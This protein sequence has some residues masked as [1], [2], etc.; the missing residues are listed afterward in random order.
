MKIN[1]I[2]E[3]IHVDS[4]GNFYVEHKNK[5][6]Q[7]NV[8][9]NNEPYFD[10]GDYSI[11]SD[12][13]PSKCDMVITKSDTFVND[14]YF[15]E[16]NGHVYK[17]IEYDDDQYIVDEPLF[18]FYNKKTDKINVYDRD[19][20]DINALYDIFIYDDVDTN[21]NSQLVFQSKLPNEI[22]AYRANVYTSG[23]F[24]FRSIG[25]FV[26]H[27]YKIIIENDEVKCIKE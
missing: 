14:R 13:T 26:E 27:K 7:L 11:I 21:V 9:G 5:L 12:N 1:G 18:V 3:N 23:K 20:G 10:P 22:C 8:D 24:F 15:P 19:N 16:D 25:C 2:D 17:N 4:H 6:Y